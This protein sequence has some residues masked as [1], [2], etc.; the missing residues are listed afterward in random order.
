LRSARTCN[1][2]SGLGDGDMSRRGA[3]HV[4][5][6]RRGRRVKDTTDISCASGGW[7]CQWVDTNALGR[8]GIPSIVTIARA[9][10]LLYHAGISVPPTGMRRAAGGGS[11]QVWDSSRRRPPAP[12]YQLV[13]HGSRPH[14]PAWLAPAPPRMAR[15][16]PASACHTHTC[17]SLATGRVVQTAHGLTRCPPPTTSQRPL[18]GMVGR[19]RAAWPALS[20]SAP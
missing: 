19:R 2:S 3:G 12:P 7:R 6:Q 18:V 8:C 13:P 11:A 10:T 5:A 4:G 14:R 17:R 20:R 1:Q 16:H 9:S 15:P